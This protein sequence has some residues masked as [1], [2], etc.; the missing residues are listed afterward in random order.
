MHRLVLPFLFQ[1]K[2]DIDSETGPAA[3][4]CLNIAILA[5]SDAGAA[6]SAAAQIMASAFIGMN[7][8]KNRPRLCTVRYVSAFAAAAMRGFAERVAAEWGPC[9]FLLR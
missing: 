1:I 3:R 5:S 4:I 7:Y 2:S 9:R 8:T 6:A